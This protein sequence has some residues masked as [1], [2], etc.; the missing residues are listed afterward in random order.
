MVGDRIA[1]PPI[2]LT[3]T[4]QVWAAAPRLPTFAAG[5]VVTGTVLAIH[6]H[7]IDRHGEVSTTAT[8][9]DREAGS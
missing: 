5:A 1:P 2:A 7:G 4:G 9:P 3:I 6:L 8:V